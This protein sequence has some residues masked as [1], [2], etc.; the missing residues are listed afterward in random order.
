MRRIWR[1]RCMMMMMMRR[2]RRCRSGGGGD[3][4][5]VSGINLELIAMHVLLVYRPAEKSSST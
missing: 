4:S 3:L 2:R 5:H 1:R